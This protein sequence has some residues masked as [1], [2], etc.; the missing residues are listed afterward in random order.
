MK[1][2]LYFSA[3]WCGPCKMLKPRLEPLR[4]QMRI[5]DINVDSSPETAQQWRVRNIPTIIVTNGTD[6]VGRLIG[7]SITPQSITELFNK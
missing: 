4:S 6:E 5:V 1:Q 3:P 2:V 7:S